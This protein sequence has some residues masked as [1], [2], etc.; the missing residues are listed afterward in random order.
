MSKFNVEN[1]YYVIPEIAAFLGGIFFTALIFL[2][3]KK[4]TFSNNFS[5]WIITIPVSEYT[6]ISFFLSMT[7]LFYMLSTITFGLSFGQETSILDRDV[8]FSRNLFFVG[9]FSSILSIYTLFLLID[10]RIALLSFCIGVFIIL[11]WMF[12]W[13]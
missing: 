3:D 9:C 13:I 4:E 8:F 12:H 11:A 2:I 5:I 1:A 7:A 6:I 10:P